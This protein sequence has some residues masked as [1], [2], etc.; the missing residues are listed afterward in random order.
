MFELA[1]KLAREKIKIKLSTQLEF[2][3]IQV[4]RAIISCQYLQ[5]ALLHFC[6]NLYNV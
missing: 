1:N 5:Y 6:F 4:N 3:L 2:T